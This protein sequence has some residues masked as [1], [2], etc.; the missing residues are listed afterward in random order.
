MPSPVSDGKLKFK[1]TP[2][3]ENPHNSD[4]PPGNDYE[5]TIKASDGELATSVS[6]TVKVTDVNEPP[7]VASEI[8]DQTM[9]VGDSTTISISGTFSDPDGDT[10]TYSVATSDDDI[11]TASVSGSTLTLTA[12]STGSATITVTAADRASGNSDRLTATDE[13]TVT[14]ED[15]TPSVK[16]TRHRDTPA[17]V[18]E[19]GQLK[20]TLTASSAPTAD[21]EVEITVAETDPHLPGR[22]ATFISDPIPDEVTIK[23]G[24]DDRGACSHDGRR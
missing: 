1:I 10:L 14:V 19:G 22:I 5:I 15:A 12:V 23:T 8:A 17:N 20:F 2:D 6:I 7:T 16:I 24:K 18:T 9:N 4:T 13:F 21:L 11:A 3:F